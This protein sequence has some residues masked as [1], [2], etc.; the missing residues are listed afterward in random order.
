MPY[1]SEKNLLNEFPELQIVNNPYTRFYLYRRYPL[2]V[3][4]DV[5]RSPIMKENY[6]FLNWYDEIVDSNNLEPDTFFASAHNMI[7]DVFIAY[8]NNF[9]IQN[10]KN[11]CTSRNINYDKMTDSEAIK[12]RYEWMIEPLTINHYI[13][14]ISAQE[15]LRYIDLT[16]TLGN[17]LIVPKNFGQKKASKFHESFFQS[18]RYLE[19]NFPDYKNIYHTNNF[20]QWKMKFI[21]E[22]FY[23]NNELFEKIS[24]AEKSLRQEK[25]YKLYL[26]TLP[27]I[28]DLIE[29]RTKK[30]IAKIIEYQK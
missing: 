6:K 14:I 8:D 7:H 9:Y 25:N 18:L 11:Y 20:E 5:D 29:K 1:T 4:S 28:S 13:E 30:I 17:F 2:N 19:D 15:F 21:L 26:M 27:L 22:D 3:I 24:N 12:Y 10:F 16:H 23:E